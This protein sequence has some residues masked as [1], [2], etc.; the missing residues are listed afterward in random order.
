MLVAYMFNGGIPDHWSTMA[1]LKIGILKLVLIHLFL[2]IDYLKLQAQGFNLQ[3]LGVTNPSNIFTYLFSRA[4]AFKQGKGYAI[5]W[6]VSFAI[7]VLAL[8]A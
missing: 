2:K 8:L 4:K 6:C 7:E 1:L 3:Q 5:T